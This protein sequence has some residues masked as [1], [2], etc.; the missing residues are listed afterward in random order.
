MLEDINLTETPHK[1]G[2]YFFISNNEIIYVGSSKDLYQRFK[3]HRQS[4]KKGGAN[5]SQKDFYQFLQTNEF[6]VEFELTFEYRQKEQE[7][8][9]KYNPRFNQVRA[10]AKC[11][12]WSDIKKYQQE[13]YLK[14]QKQYRNEHKSKIKQQRKK[15]YESHKEEIK[16]QQKQCSDQ[17]CSYNDEVLTLNTLSQRFIR[18][19]IPH[20]TLEA[21]KYLIKSS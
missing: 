17:L 14:Y 8:I 12:S 3:Q 6:Q 9:E 4:I 21:K 16:K 11:G 19:G 20:P 18:Q 13:Y 1:S 5:K 10:C 15:Y 7:L 2:V